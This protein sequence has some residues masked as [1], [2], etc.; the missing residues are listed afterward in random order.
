MRQ[1]LSPRPLSR[2]ETDL[3]DEE[4][5]VLASL[6]AEHPGARYFARLRL[7]TAAGERDVVLGER[8]WSNA[9]VAMIDWRSAPL[10]E[11]FF[12]S[13]PGDDYELEHEGRSLTGEVLRRHLVHLQGS[14]LV[15]LDLA[16]CR[17]R[18]G[19]DGE[20]YADDRGS[21]RVA[22]RP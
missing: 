18:R 4:T 2:L 15:G 11:V 17:L 6:L 22:P 5:R 1:P 10:A 9:R 8:G 12:N 20:W 19:S 13:E 16:D 14:E 21:P 7:R 3:I